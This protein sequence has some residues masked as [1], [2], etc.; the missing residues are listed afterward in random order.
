MRTATVALLAATL[1]ATGATAAGADTLVTAAP[2]AR[3]L[4][5]NRGSRPWAPRAAG[6]RGGLPARPPDGSVPT[7]PLADF[8]PPP[9]PQIGSPQFAASGRPLLAV[10]SR[11]QGASATA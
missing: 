11:C 2:G 7:P 4:T 6:G 8:G 9:R 10:S 1:L 5:A 3:N